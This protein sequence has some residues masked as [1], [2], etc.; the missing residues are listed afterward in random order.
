M[1]EIVRISSN[2]P[3]EPV[4]AY[5]RAVRAGD[6]LAVSGTTGFDERGV[7]VGVNQMYVQARQ[8]LENIRKALERAGVPM[9]NVIRTRMFVTDISRFAEIARAHREYFADARPASTAVEVKRLVHPDMLIEIEADAYAPEP[10][11][12][13][14]AAARPGPPA[15]RTKASKRAKGNAAKPKRRAAKRGRPR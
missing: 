8:A 7:V 12:S 2:A 4:A 14:A 11:A 6:F 1:R 13:R 9:R 3:W 10:A 15:A 5:S